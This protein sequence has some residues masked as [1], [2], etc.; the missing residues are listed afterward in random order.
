M[1][2]DKAKGWANSLEYGEITTWEDLIEKFMKKH[3]SPIDNARRS[4]DL[5]L[6]K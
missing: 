3:F 1:L 2:K 4:Q 5:M 6:F